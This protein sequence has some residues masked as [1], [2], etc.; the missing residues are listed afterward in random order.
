MSVDGST[1]HDFAPPSSDGAAPQ[2][3]LIPAPAPDTLRDYQWTLAM[4]EVEEDDAA[5]H[6][7]P[8]YQSPRRSGLPTMPAAVLKGPA[9]YDTAVWRVDHTT[10]AA[11]AGPATVQASLDTQLPA[12]T[13]GHLSSFTLAKETTRA[14]VPADQSYVDHEATRRLARLD[15]YSTVLAD[16]LH[17]KLPLEEPLVRFSRQMRPLVDQVVGHLRAQAERQQS[18]VLHLALSETDEARLRNTIS[19]GL[20]TSSILDLP[21]HASLAGVVDRT[22]AAIINEHDATHNPAIT[23]FRADLLAQHRRQDM[24]VAQAGPEYFALAEV[25]IARAIKANHSSK[26]AQAP[27][28]M[29]LGDRWDPALRA[30]VAQALETNQINPED[31]TIATLD[32]LTAAVQGA[33][34]QGIL[35]RK[36]PQK[37]ETPAEQPSVRVSSKPRAQTIGQAYRSAPGSQPQKSNPTPLPK[38]DRQPGSRPAP[39]RRSAPRPTVAEQPARRATPPQASRQPSRRPRSGDAAPAARSRNSAASAPR[40][41]Y[42]S[43][44]PEARQRSAPPARTGQSSSAES[45]RAPAARPPYRREQVAAT[46]QSSQPARAEPSSGTRMPARRPAQP[47]PRQTPVPA[48]RSQPQQPTVRREA[49]PVG[50]MWRN[51]SPVGAGP[52]VLTRDDW[53]RPSRGIALW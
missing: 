31:V 14:V 6:G 8:T 2:R 39:R 38:A 5:L 16:G 27:G 30:S 45:R 36:P 4:A 46:R 48:R 20:Q 23:R 44:P 17:P 50:R 53:L 10:F 12:P 18:E 33:A 25:V 35:R 24:V 32:Q 52:R 13:A 51:D 7:N 34:A 40:R 9:A 47:S 15:R 41:S 21:A 26:T 29:V 42:T 43:T 28:Q 49:Q 1:F 22:E 11:F 3:Q 37:A 19:V